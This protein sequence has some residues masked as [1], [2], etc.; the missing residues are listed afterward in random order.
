M[1]FIWLDFNVQRLHLRQRLWRKGE[2]EKA[3]QAR[4]EWCVG[5]NPEAGSLRCRLP[6][7]RLWPFL[8]LSV[9]R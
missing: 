8:T 6:N 2:E 7:L 9:N 5:S 4:V 3:W 1:A